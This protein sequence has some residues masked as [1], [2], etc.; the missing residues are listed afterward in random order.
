MKAVRARRRIEKQGFI[1]R[2]GAAV[3][4]EKRVARRVAVEAIG[5]CAAIFERVVM[6]FGQLQ[7]VFSLSLSIR[8]SR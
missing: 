7:R 1:A 4:V 3:R 2:A 8:L 6:R 5:Q